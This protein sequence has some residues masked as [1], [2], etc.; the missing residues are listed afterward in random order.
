MHNDKW[1]GWPLTHEQLFSCSILIFHLMWNWIFCVR[2][3]LLNICSWTHSHSYVMPWCSMQTLNEIVVGSCDCL[4]LTQRNRRWPI[5]NRTECSLTDLFAQCLH[6]RRQ[7]VFATPHFL[8]PLSTVTWFLLIFGI[9]LAE[10][11]V[12]CRHLGGTS[13]YAAEWIDGPS[14]RLWCCNASKRM[15]K[16][17][18]AH[19]RWAL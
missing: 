13:C 17:E 15:S 18:H 10:P 8:W 7:N 5:S 3:C 4:N 12:G 6:K 9:H 14:G 1:W 11:V 2:L 16:I 19:W